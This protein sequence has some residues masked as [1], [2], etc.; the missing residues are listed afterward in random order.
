MQ[1]CDNISMLICDDVREESGNKISIMGLFDQVI[2][3]KNPITT[4]PQLC[5]FTILENVHVKL[6]KV[7]FTIINPENKKISFTLEIKNEKKSRKNHRIIVK[8]AP[9][10]IA[11][12][13][14]Y[15]IILS[16]P[17]TKDSFFEKK[18]AI[19]SA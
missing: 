7:V 11:G 1:I 17:D 5:F 12:F 13:G 15:R 8:L 19:K 14:E 10:Q 9:F 18:L 2:L 3:V 6:E 16:L 4:L